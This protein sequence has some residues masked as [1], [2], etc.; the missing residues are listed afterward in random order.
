MK[1]SWNQGNKTLPKLVLT[2]EDPDFDQV[3]TANWRAEGFEVSYLPFT[4]SR[5]DYVTSVQH[6]ADP[7]ELGE[8]YAIVGLLLLRARARH[9]MATVEAEMLTSILSAAYGEAASMVLDVAVKP[10]PKLCALVA[11]YPERLP[12]P[13]AGFPSSHNVL[14]HTAGSQGMM[15]KYRS[16]SYPEAQPGFAEEDL[17]EYDKISTSLAWSRTLATVRKGFEIE[18]DLEK[19]W[20][21]HVAR[22]TPFMDF[23]E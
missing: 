14:V 13:A 6:L 18:K 3:T 1:F 23:L 10:M 4:G 17:D 9:R 7:L 2:A 15:P 22:E 16:Y 19:V 5:K 21:E 20:E 11:Y 8:K 12:T